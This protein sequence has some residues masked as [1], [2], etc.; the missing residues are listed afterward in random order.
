MKANIFILLVSLFFTSP[1]L[2]SEA[3]YGKFQSKSLYI[4]SALGPNS[5]SVQ[6]TTPSEDQTKNPQLPLSNEFQSVYNGYKSYW[7]LLQSNKP[8]DSGLVSWYG[9]NLTIDSDLDGIPDFEERSLP[10]NLTASVSTRSDVYGVANGGTVTL[11]REKGQTTGNSVTAFNT[12]EVFSGSWQL[13]IIDVS[14]A[15]F[16]DSGGVSLK[17]ESTVFEAGVITGKYR[18]KTDDQIEFFDIIYTLKSGRNISLNTIAFQRYNKTYRATIQMYDGNLYTSYPDYKDWIMQLT[19]YTD[20]D[21]DGIPDISDATPLGGLPIIVGN[22]KDIQVTE[23]KNAIFS[24]KLAEGNYK[25]QWYL[26]NKLIVNSTNSEITINSVTD[27]YAGLYKVLVQNLAGGIFSDEAKLTVIPAIISPSI[28]TQPQNKTVNSGETVDFF[29]S[30]TG[31]PPFSYQWQNNWVNIPGANYSTY[32]ITSAQTINN[33]G[34]SVIV[35]NS[36]GFVSSLQA[37]LIIKTNQTTSRPTFVVQPTNMTLSLGS[38]LKMSVKV[39]SSTLIQYQWF[40]NNIQIVSATNS[41][42]NISRIGFSDYG[43]YF[44]LAYNLAG[45]VESLR[46]TISLPAERAKVIAGPIINQANGMTYYFLSPSAW[47]VAA[48]TARDLG[49]FLA[50]ISDSNMQNWLVSQFTKYA[51]SQRMIWM[52]LS[53]LNLEGSFVWESGSTSEY[54][55][56]SKGEPNNCCGGE[57]FAA[58]YIDHNGIWNDFGSTFKL[59]GVVEVS[60][61]KKPINNLA[62]RLVP[63]ITIEGTLN[64]NWNIEYSTSL[65]YEAPWIVLTN[66]TLTQSGKQVIDLS[67]ATPARFYRAI[68]GA[69]NIPA[70]MALIPNGVFQMGAPIEGSN[71][72]HIVNISSFAIDR[73]EVTKDLWDAVRSWGINNGYDLIQGQSFPGILQPVHSINWYDAV[74]WCNARSEMN[75]IPPVYYTDAGLKFVYRSGEIIPYTKRNKGYRLPS[76]AEWE[77]AARGGSS[78]TEYSWTGGLQISPSK[79]NYIDSNI[80]QTTPV[81]SFSGNGYGLYNMSGNVWEWCWDYYAPYLEVP[82]TDPLGSSQG[83]ARVIRGGGWDNSSVYCRVFSRISNGTPTTRGSSL[84]F[85]TA[86][87][88]Q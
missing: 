5:M 80:N 62:V 71:P 57:N 37:V 4:N 15:Y 44:V 32:S 42:Y 33:G 52:G 24:V 86:I 73:Y 81:S 74:K 20:S 10:V 69:T 13:P 18:R 29:V 67:E 19:D 40:K 21:N 38:Q 53:D 36:S 43:E 14:G 70:D 65:S 6:F 48:A 61:P 51:D 1:K 54:R 23:G 60:P 17:T 31:T 28:V 78:V 35:G 85:R 79:A 64:S 26:N 63:E 3:L 55:N 59:N 27:Q 58:F 50:T 83:T 84:G 72:A 12:G 11:T 8:I 22:P 88:V 49:G 87:S 82:Q 68:G 39:M 34:Y 30:A 76:E 2:Y 77:R 47:P 75:K 46:S 7:I 56:W 25:Y 16:K 41:D 66:L 45:A 9:P